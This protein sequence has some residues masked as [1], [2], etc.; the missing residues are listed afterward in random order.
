MELRRFFSSPRKWIDYATTE[1]LCCKLYFDHGIM[2]IV[3]IVYYLKHV[4]SVYSATYLKRLMGYC[5]S[6]G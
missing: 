1:T 2:D 4:S 6:A 5:K 3:H